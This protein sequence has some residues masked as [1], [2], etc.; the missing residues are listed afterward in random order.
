[1]TPNDS[2]P[3]PRPCPRSRCFPSGGSESSRTQP[4]RAGTK[5]VGGRFFV[6]LS[7]TSR[8]RGYYTP[9][10]ARQEI[11]SA[12]RSDSASA[13]R[14]G[15]RYP[16]RSPA[17]MLMHEAT[18]RST[19]TR[20]CTAPA[21]HPLRRDPGSTGTRRGR[22]LR[23]D[24]ALRQGD[25]AKLVPDTVKRSPATLRQCRRPVPDDPHRGQAPR[26]GPSSP[27]AQCTEERRVRTRRVMTME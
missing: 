25:G 16:A 27:G 22:T 23:L 18:P 19:P 17:A 14:G 1:M 26:Y 13:G 6:V 10:Q 7:K 11:A 8:V 9:P 20:R 12:A 3:A 21:V 5:P 15:L 4:G 2:R 24:G